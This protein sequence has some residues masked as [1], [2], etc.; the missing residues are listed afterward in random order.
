MT[1]KY[2]FIQEYKALCEKHGLT[3]MPAAEFG[4]AAKDDKLVVVNLTE[5]TKDYLENKVLVVVEYQSMIKI[6][7]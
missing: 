4:L 2:H 3:M 6:K 5:D 1:N 7:S